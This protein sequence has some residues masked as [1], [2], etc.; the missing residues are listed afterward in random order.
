MIPRRSVHSPAPLSLMQQRL[1]FLTQLKGSPAYYNTAK[2]FVLE[3]ALDVGALEKALGELVRRHESLRT[4]FDVVDGEP[5][6][7]INPPR[8]VHLPLVELGHVPPAE[9]EA[10]AIRLANEEAHRP[11]DL[12]AEPL[13][14]FRVLRLNEQEHVI[15]FTIHHLVTDRVSMA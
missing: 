4:T 13:C 1:W 5:M 9:R 7:I 14:R 10:E 6:Q 8:P 2:A 11:F 15:L 12:T 3:G